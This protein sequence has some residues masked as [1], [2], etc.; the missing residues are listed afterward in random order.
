MALQLSAFP[1]TYPDD[2]AKQ[3]ITTVARFEQLIR[4]L[5]TR[6]AI[7]V[8][9][10]TSGLAWFKHA[11][12]VGVGLASWDDSGHI[13]NAYIPV[14]HRT[15]GPQLSMSVV[16]PAVQK[17]LADPTTLKVGH[18]I[19][20]EDHFARKEG[21][22]ILG[23]RYDTMVGARLYDDNERFLK[24]EKR[25]ETDLGIK[26]AMRWNHLLNE[27]IH[28]LARANRMGIEDYKFKYGYSEVDPNLCGIYCCTDTS[29]TAQLH[30]LYERWGVS[31]HFSRIWQ[32]EMRLTS[33]LCDMEQVGMLIDTEYLTGVRAQVRQAKEVLE[34]QL[35]EAMGG[36][37]FNVA[38]DDELRSTLWHVLGFRWDKKTQG[39][40]YSVDSE[41]LESFADSSL[42]CR[43]ILDWRNADKIDTTYTTSI[44]EKLDDKNYL[45]G[46][47]KQVGTSTGRL[48]SANPN[49]Q[50]FVADDDDR[51]LAATGKRLKEGGRDPWSIRRAFVVADQGRWARVICDYAQ[52][53]LKVLAHYSKDPIMCEAFI[54]GEDIHDRT[55][56]EVGQ[57]L[58]RECPRRVAK[59][60][61]FGLSYGMSEKGLATQAK[62][63]EDDAA[64]FL[65]AFFQRYKGIPAF[66]NELYAQAR[67]DQCQWRN[68]FGR[69]RRIPDL[70]APEFWKAR[71]AERQLIGSAIQGTAAE[72]TK[73]SLVRIS[74]FFSAEKLPAFLVTTIHDEIQVDTPRE[75]LPE[76]VKA[77]KRLME[78]FPEFAPIPITAEASVTWTNWA[79]KRPYKEETNE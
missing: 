1:A 19:K 25:A 75:C 6:K 12:I 31:T 49:L 60:V 13:W 33:V 57:L 61:A 18:N 65:G 48:A 21:W 66:R 73:E 56:A 34:K 26:D 70:K 58:G 74:D 36:Y 24:L 68:L 47:L 41:V 79:D 72:L 43:L 3:L 76:V 16:G 35:I 17:L 7:V 23:P 54:K 50:N 42:V 32:T 69:V 37:R 28:R 5:Q 55:A 38:S 9:F 10:E 39:D 53:E 4:W 64:S 45:H 62:I 71:R 59:V 15:A 40:Q 30:D 22:Q 78:N 14:R 11:Q 67:R 52:I 77:V 63:S 46:D 20:F 27:E 51:A 2:P 29:H 44:L 8:D